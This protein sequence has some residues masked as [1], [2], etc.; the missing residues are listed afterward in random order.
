MK[1]GFTYHFGKNPAWWLTFLAIT[2]AL[3]VLDL[4]IDACKKWW[5]PTSV[6]IWQELEQDET[7]KRKILE[8]GGEGGYSVGLWDEER[9]EV[10][11][12]EEDDEEDEG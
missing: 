8:V 2:A 7:V 12:T 3:V 10:E 6:E 4:A 9:R 11:R 1:D 5:W